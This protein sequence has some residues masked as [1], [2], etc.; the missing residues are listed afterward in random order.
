MFQEDEENT[1]SIKEGSQKLQQF[2]R[3]DNTDNISIFQRE[4][5]ENVLL[6]MS[7]EENVSEQNG[8]TGEECQMGNRRP[9]S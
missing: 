4:V 8:R 1:V 3:V 7:L 2:I 6:L 5:L 9:G